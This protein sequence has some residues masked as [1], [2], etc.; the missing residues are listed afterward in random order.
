MAEFADFE[1]KGVEQS[2]EQLQKKLVETCTAITEEVRKSLVSVIK[3]TSKVEIQA[4]Q[5]S[6]MDG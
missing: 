1:L 5:T 3:E 6:S 4:P 2:V